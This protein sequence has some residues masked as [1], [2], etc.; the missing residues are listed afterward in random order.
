MSRLAG[1]A[2]AY[3]RG[4]RRTRAPEKRSTSTGYRGENTRLLRAEESTPRNGWP[5]SAALCSLFAASARPVGPAIVKRLPKMT[6]EADRFAGHSDGGGGLRSTHVLR[7]F[8]VL[9]DSL[10]V[11]D[12][13]RGGM[14]YLRERFGDRYDVHSEEGRIAAIFYYRFGRE[15]RYALVKR[16]WRQIENLIRLGELNE[17]PLT[18]FRSIFEVLLDVRFIRAVAIDDPAFNVGHI[19]A[20]KVKE[21]AFVELCNDLY[22][23]ATAV[24]RLLDCGAV[25]RRKRNRATEESLESL[26]RRNRRAFPPR[27]DKIVP[28]LR[29][30]AELIK[31]NRLLAKHREQNVVRE[32]IGSLED[33]SPSEAWCLVAGT[34]AEVTWAQLLER[35][36]ERMLSLGS[37]PQL[38]GFFEALG[39]ARDSLRESAPEHPEA[40]K[41]FLDDMLWRK[42]L[43]PLRPGSPLASAD[44]VASQTPKLDVV[45]ALP[46]PF[47]EQVLCELKRAVGGVEDS[48]GG[49]RLVDEP[50]EQQSLSSESGS[51]APCEEQA[52]SCFTLI[53]PDVWKIRFREETYQV[54]KHEVSTLTVSEG[55]ALTIR[56]GR[57]AR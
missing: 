3:F 39:L 57:R 13:L 8:V 56:E 52:H 32:R 6:R 28:P 18:Q 53:A 26:R 14:D 15:S 27:G 54:V 10:F 42:A 41:L 21:P 1:F 31:T 16:I 20:L 36:D 11:V 9:W 49:G 43:E 30:V 55:L 44:S 12:D 51:P 38:R 48:Q 46:V 29:A 35:Y 19:H 45:A 23:A 34:A 7:E 2:T 4:L 5:A 17:K 25:E 37:C 22:A 40:N 47:D 33:K 50:T 24:K